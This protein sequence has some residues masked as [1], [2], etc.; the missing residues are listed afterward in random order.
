MCGRF[1][2]NSPI[3]L[4]VEI[5]NVGSTMSGASA[6]YNVAPSQEILII[7][8]KGKRELVKCRWGFLPPWVKDLSEGSRMI[9]ARAETLDEKSSFKAAFKK[10]RCLIIADGFYEWKKEKRKKVPYYIRLKSA[11]PFGFAGL[12]NQWTSP[13][14]EKICS[15]TIITSEANDLVATIHDR[16]PAI[17]PHEKVDMWLD[18][19]FQDSEML[20]RILRPYPS[21]EIEMYPVSSKINSVKMDSAT[22]IMPIDD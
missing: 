4:I 7:N 14:G 20:K 6:S 8:D 9:N 21:E 15:C 22:N 13:D 5:F 16:M 1:V 19:G 3:S 11:E 17:V 12:Y 18:P 10:Q 2:R